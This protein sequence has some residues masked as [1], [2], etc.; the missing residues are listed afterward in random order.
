MD[1]R[2]KEKIVDRLQECSTPED[3]FEVIQ[4]IPMEDI[5]DVIHD[6]VVF[7]EILNDDG[8]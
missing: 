5:A 6:L 7:I 2:E 3:V 1:P 4:D 8:R